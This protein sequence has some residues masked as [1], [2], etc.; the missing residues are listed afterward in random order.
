MKYCPVNAWYVACWS[1]DLAKGQALGRKFLDQD[2]ALF[3][4]ENGSVNALHDRCPHRFAPLSAGVVRNGI[5]QC[6][7]HGLEFDGSGAC[8]HNPYGPVLRS[9]AVR[10]YPIAERHRAIWIWMGDAEAADEN[11]IPDLSV[12]AEAPDSA[13]SSGYL[14]TQCNFEIVIDNILDL[15]HTDYLHANSIAGTGMTTSS[16]PVTRETKDGLRVEWLASDI[17]LSP[18]HARLYPDIERADQVVRMDWYAPAAIRLDAIFMPTGQPEEKGFANLN[19]HLMTPETK[20]TTHYFFAATR[21][22]QL[23]DEALNR[24]VAEARYKV[25]STEDKPILNLVQERMGDADF[26]DLK[27]LLLGVDEAAVRARRWIAKM[28]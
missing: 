23:E 16:K 19:L 6:P 3:R 27:P 8:T 10:S 26:W 15:T 14:H 7:Y 21:T 17:P 25:F 4:A 5:L 12:L 24:S 22:Y 9:A 28:P 18:F 2:V 13:F 11:L 20:T 1:A